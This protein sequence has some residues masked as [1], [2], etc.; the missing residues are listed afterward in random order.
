MARYIG[1]GLAGGIG[2]LGASI[3]GGLMAS[4]GLEAI[5]RNPFAKRKLKANLY[6]SILAFVVAAGLAVYA[7]FLIIR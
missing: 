5:G 7:A 6:V 2:I 4:K 3:G 1:A